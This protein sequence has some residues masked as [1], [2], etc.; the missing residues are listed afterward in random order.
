MEAMPLA[1]QERATRRALLYATDTGPF[2]DATWEALERQH[3]RWCGG[4]LNG[5]AAVR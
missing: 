2:P 1:V 3:G 5:A 4:T